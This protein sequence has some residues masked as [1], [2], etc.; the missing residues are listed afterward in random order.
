MAEIKYTITHVYT[1]IQN[2][3]LSSCKKPLNLCT[4]TTS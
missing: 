4:N 1:D 3:Y 2:I